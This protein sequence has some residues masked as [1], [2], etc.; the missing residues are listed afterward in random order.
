METMFDLLIDEMLKH[1]GT[2]GFLLDGYPRE[3]KQ[4][5]HFEDR[6]C[7]CNYVMYFDVTDTTMVSV[8]FSPH[9]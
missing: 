7:H 1:T 3:L 9:F 4:G 2:V 5:Q 6:V 8:N